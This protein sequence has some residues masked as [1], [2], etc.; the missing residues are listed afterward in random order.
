MVHLHYWDSD[1][2]DSKSSNVN[3]AEGPQLFEA[4]TSPGANQFYRL[5]WADKVDSTVQRPWRI[6]PLGNIKLIKTG[7]LR[8]AFPDKGRL[9]PTVAG[10]IDR[11]YGPITVGLWQQ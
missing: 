2:L 6:N 11:T 10:G 3:G 1:G 9:N 7:T 8:F 4:I 5:S